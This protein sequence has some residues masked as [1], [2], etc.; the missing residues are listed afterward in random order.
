[1]IILLDMD[2]VICDWVASASKAFDINP[3][4]LEARYTPGVYDIEHALG[5]SQE[6]LWQTV[7]SLGR[8]FWANI[9][10]YPWAHEMWDHCRNLAPTYFLSK[11]SYDPLSLAGKLDWIHKFT[12]DPKFDGF[13][14][15]P[16][17]ELCAAPHRVLV[18]DSD[19]NCR[20]FEAA[21]GRAIVFP[22]IWNSRHAQKAT[23]METAMADLASVVLQ[24][25]S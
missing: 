10:P 17:K 8:E 12:G 2:G 5:V 7:N 21:G 9:K 16:R 1:M 11:P 23:A 6:T 19:D 22:R 18:D 24:E 20:K 25:N 3:D 14:I 15:G 13:L 4:D